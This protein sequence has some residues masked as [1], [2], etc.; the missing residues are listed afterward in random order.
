M[1]KNL[2]M[3]KKYKIARH[4]S[5][6]HIKCNICT[7]TWGTATD[8][9]I[10]FAIIFQTIRGVFYESPDGVMVLSI[11]DGFGAESAGMQ[12]GAWK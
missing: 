5:W 10:L 2:I 7:S 12:V 8:K 6:C 9:P 4:R 11:L 3:Q 1:R